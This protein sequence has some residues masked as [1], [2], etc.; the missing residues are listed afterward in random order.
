MSD[1]EDKMEGVEEGAT[2][3]QQTDLAT[4]KAKAR[5]VVQEATDKH[6][7]NGASAGDPEENGDSSEDNGVHENG[8]SVDG[9]TEDEMTGGEEEEEEGE[10]E[11]ASGVEENGSVED[12]TDP[13]GAGDDNDDPLNDESTND[14]TTTDGKNEDRENGGEDEGEAEVIEDDE[15]NQDDPLGNDIH[16]DDAKAVNGNSKSSSD[17]DKKDKS[18]SSEV[19]GEIIEEILDDD[20]SK[21]SDDE[22]EIII[23][24][25]N[26]TK[27]KPASSPKKLSTPKKKKIEEVTLDDTPLRRSS[28]KKTPKKYDEMEKEY[29]R[30]VEAVEE[31]ELVEEI[32]EIK[33][34]DSDIQEVDIEDPLTTPSTASISITKSTKSGSGKK[35]NVVTIDDLKTL[36]LLATSAKKTIDSQKKENRL[37]T[38][39]IL[40]GKMGSG[41]SITP[42]K[43]K[44]NIGASG[45][46]LGSG[47]T[48][49]PN[50]PRTPMAPSSS[51][52][53]TNTGGSLVATP[54]SGSTTPVQSS[55]PA[56]QQQQ[57]EN[58]SYDPNLTDDTFVVEAPSFI[59]PYVYEKPP[60][61][62]I[63]SFLE[64]IKKLRAELEEKEKKEAEEKKKEEK[65]KRRE[66]RQ[67][68]RDD[69]EENVSDDSEDEDKEEKDVKNEDEKER[70]KDKDEK[71][72]KEESKE[73][74]SKDAATS[75]TKKPESLKTPS[76]QY[77]G[78]TLGKFF[79]EL[80][81][82]LV[83][84]YVQ[85]DLLASQKRRAQRDK[86]VAVLHAISSLQK[87][88]DDSEDTNCVFHHDMRKCRFCSF[89]TESRVV[90]ANHMETP[91]MRNFIYRCN[92]CEFETKIPQEVLFHMDSI[93]GVKGKL[94]RAPYYHQCPQ[95]SFEDNGKGKLTRHRMGCDKRFKPELNLMPDRDWDPPAKIRAQPSRPGY[96]NTTQYI[97]RGVGGQQ[98]QQFVQGNVGGM[99]PGYRVGTNVVQPRNMSPAGVQR[100]GMMSAASRNAAMA[101]RGRP[102]GTY[103]GPGSGVDLRIPQPNM[104]ATA[105]AAQQNRLRGL[106]PQMMSGQQMLAALNSQGLSVLG[107][108]GKNLSPGGVNKG[109]AP[110][111]SIT[112]LPGRN[113][114]AANAA[115]AAANA[116]KA[117]PSPMMKPG[118]PGG[119]GKGNF[120]ICE[121]CDGYIKDLEQLRNH[122]QWIHKVKIHPKMIHNRPPLNCQKCQYRFF[123]DQGLERHL[124]GSHGLVTASM[125][126]AANKGQD[127]GRCPVCGKVY[128][129][130]LLNHVAK[131]HN[132]TL[133]P[134]HLSYKC[135]VCTATFGQYKLF[136]NHVYTA[137]S[138]VAKKADKNKQVAGTSGGGS[139]KPMVKAAPTPPQPKKQPEKAEVIDLDDEEE[140]K[141]PLATD[142]TTTPASTTEVIDL[143]ST[144]KKRPTP[145]ATVTPAE[146]KEEAKGTKRSNEDGNSD[147]E[148]KKAKPSEKESEG[149]DGNESQDTEG[150]DE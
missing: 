41:V 60:K 57:Q 54:N 50:T 91:H 82:N 21:P 123:T 114:P 35:P 128:Q 31:A 77:F 43:P 19:N 49:K 55:S 135:T 96:Q 87:N 71:E 69:G 33:D 136:E 66:E 104:A 112:A 107:S 109:N 63:K 149:E 34:D 84:E 125:Q 70:D 143:D 20:D 15:S 108:G 32:E 85:R 132:K 2:G 126:D 81:M 1:P 68:R 37:D 118:Q 11:E 101:N 44:L 144:P 4:L 80:G 23:E 26:T 95:C 105:A 102:V 40:A 122:M 8:T 121:I 29:D 24:Q 113:S 93:H 83:Q 58:E 76:E 106:S 65:K 28:R 90:M 92:F 45:L 130:K 140:E 124:L 150:G 52:T 133:K 51:V 25:D 117:S 10:G 137:H 61:E 16:S 12:S 30:V 72:D 39:A 42:A 46:T 64:E 75:E 119:Q 9:N 17:T 148:A 22:S 103:K 86:S 27:Q 142:S 53:I 56:P 48:I 47:V 38:Q 129:W 62:E 59:V 88:I 147:Q 111:I 115:A 94:E 73:G 100:M 139:Q 3:D 138:G 99:V 74:D 6:H 145:P 7:S 5:Q 116:K 98:Q 18:K 131:D 141:D 146:K 127:S 110:S 78:S 36:Q 89:R 14:T 134:A 120:V 67:K 13:L 97:Q 79:S